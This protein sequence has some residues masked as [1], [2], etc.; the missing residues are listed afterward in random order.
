MEGMKTFEVRIWVDALYMSDAIERLEDGNETGIVA[1]FDRS[2]LKE[3][4]A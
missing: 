1:D 4:K 3:V 2:S